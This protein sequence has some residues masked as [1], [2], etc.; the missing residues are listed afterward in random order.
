[1]FFSGQRGIIS[2]FKKKGEKP[3]KLAYERKKPKGM[4]VGLSSGEFSMSLLLKNFF[5]LLAC[6][7]A[8]Q[9]SLISQS[10]MLLHGYVF[11]YVP[12]MREVLIFS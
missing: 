1:M 3:R 6:A 5:L 7:M 8:R 9:I 10:C 11:S 12:L 2:D 4:V